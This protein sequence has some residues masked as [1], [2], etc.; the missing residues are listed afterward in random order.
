M[1]FDEFDDDDEVINNLFEDL[2]KECSGSLSVKKIECE[3]RSY[4]GRSEISI[5]LENLLNEM[6]AGK[7]AIT[8]K[9][10]FKKYISSFQ[11]VHGQR[12][13]WVRSLR[14]ESMLA[15]RLKVGKLFDEMSG[16][17]ETS[18][19]N[20]DEILKLFFVDVNRVVKAAW[21]EVRESR[22]TDATQSTDEVRSVVNKFEGPVGKFGNAEVFQRGLESQIGTA[23]PFILKGI[24]REHTFGGSQDKAQLKAVTSNHN[25]PFSDHQEYARILG[26]QREYDGEKET[27]LKDPNIPIFLQE[28]ATGIHHDIKGPKITELIALT[29]DFKQLRYFH[30]LVL[31]H[32]GNR[33]P[34]DVGHIQ[35]SISFKFEASDHETAKQIQSKLKV[36][37][38]WSQ[39]DTSRV[40]M[41][42]VVPDADIGDVP[43]VDID[44][45]ISS[46]C[47]TCVLYET[48]FNTLAGKVGAFQ[49]FLQS[50]YPEIA[51]ITNTYNICIYCELKCP[52]LNAHLRSILHS[53]RFELS[54]L[55]AISGLGSEESS[56]VHIQSIVDDA[57]AGRRGATRISLKQGRRHLT[58]RELMSIPDVRAAGLRVEE[59]IQ[60]YQYTG[61]MF[62]VSLSDSVG[63]KLSR[64]L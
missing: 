37:H 51:S 18:E 15:S 60:V 40:K 49:Q 42:T 63:K 16:I 32:N 59:A 56:D 62:Q 11:R 38:F 12:V 61:P 3:L 1:N 21:K 58:L 33:F 27:K 24:I 19:E 43:H 6:K 46:N 48:R 53:R 9:S 5:V 2:D 39:T 45:N 34:G 31:D 10:K 35:L 4:L 54:R 36:A 52:D 14:L 22:L 25:L 44:E 30:E 64:R 20:L 47:I 26:N 57:L 13:L 28:V 41:E 55:Q 17:R 8:D 23:D 50:Q 7:F 29:D